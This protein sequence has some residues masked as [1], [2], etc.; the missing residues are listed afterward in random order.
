[1]FAL[2]EKRS[3]SLWLGLPFFRLPS[4]WSC[5]MRSHFE[6]I[7]VGAFCWA[8]DTTLS[9]QGVLVFDIDTM[10]VLCI[11]E[12]LAFMGFH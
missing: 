1:L 12:V 5:G 4:T 9:I 8:S 6:T 2:E 3:D 11:F 7:I 10:L